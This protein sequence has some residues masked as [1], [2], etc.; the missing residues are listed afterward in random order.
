[1]LRVKASFV[2]VVLALLLIACNSRWNPTSPSNSITNSGFSTLPAW[3]PC[4]IVHTPGFA[5][6]PTLE[7]QMAEVEKL[8]R[9]GRMT[10]IRLGGDSLDYFLR[11]K[12]MGLKVFGIISLEELESMGWENAFDMK[13]RTYPADIW[14][15]AGE[16]STG[17]GGAPGENPL[18]T[19]E[20][21]MPKFKRLYEHVKRNYPKAVLTSPPTF[22]SGSDGAVELEKFIE[23]GMLDMDIIVAVNV[24]TEHALNRYASVFA[25]YGSQLAQK[26]IWVTETGMPDPNRQIEWVE[27]F[28]PKL[29]NTFHPEMICYY[30]LW[31]GDQPGGDNPFGLVTNIEN[32]QPLIERPLFKMLTEGR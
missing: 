2:A 10:W 28:Y 18:M 31:V 4:V 27:N 32:G 22:G 1:M 5:G 20:D 14:E 12:Q 29:V 24:Y 3:S 8:Q 26:R 16:I 23:L 6:D 19:P 7:N 25:K 13:Y 17:G 11:S 21:F 30:A 15:I 9:V